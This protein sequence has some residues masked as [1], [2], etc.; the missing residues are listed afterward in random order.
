MNEACMKAEFNSYYISLMLRKKTRPCPFI[1]RAGFCLV[2][3]VKASKK[4]VSKP[5]SC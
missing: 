2:K 3:S 4:D 1:R 5:H